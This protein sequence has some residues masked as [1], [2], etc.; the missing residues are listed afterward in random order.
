MQIYDKGENIKEQVPR[1]INFR[2]KI[3]S[4]DAMFIIMPCGESRI[5]MAQTC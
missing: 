5:K 3:K 4:H 2:H 1:K